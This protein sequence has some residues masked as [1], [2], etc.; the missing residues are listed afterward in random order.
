LSKTAFV[1][2]GQGSQSVGMGQDIFNEYE[3]AREYYQRANEILGFDVAEL[4]FHG[5]EDMLRQ[6]KYT[7][8]ALFVLSVIVAEILKERGVRPDMV[9]GHSLGEY[10]ALVAADALDFEQGLKLVKIRGELMQN[11]GTYQK[12][13]MAAIIGIV[14]ER[15]EKICRLASAKGIV[16]MANFNSPT[17]I[18][19]S[20][21]V[22]GVNE[23][24]RLAKLEGAKRVI[25]LNV[26]GAFH[27]P[28]MQP[29]LENFSNAVDSTDIKTPSVPIYTNVT[30]TSTVDPAEIKD[31]LKKQLVNPVLWA[32]SIENMIADGADFFVE[33]GPGSVLSN[34][35]KRI[36]RNVQVF[37]VNSVEKMDKLLNQN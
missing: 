7:Q 21:S 14:L 33:A 32:R 16:G 26:S 19:V 25:E 28:L 1:F 23:V 30:A 29:A 4:S 18:V 5:P 17:Q 34:L 35:I 8:P 24:M 36:N 10:S 31:L 6:T 20:G 13:A 15:V 37:P 11:A 3:Q 22:D 12:G 9:A 2:P 27:S